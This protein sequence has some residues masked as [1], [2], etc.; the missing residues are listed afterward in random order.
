MSERES[1]ES[2][3]FLIWHNTVLLRHLNSLEQIQQSVKKK[4][5]KKGKIK[6]KRVVIVKQVCFS[7]IFYYVKIEKVSANSCNWYRTEISIKLQH[8]K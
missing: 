7:N 4:K 8:E 5:K 3:I 2:N 6:C 1:I